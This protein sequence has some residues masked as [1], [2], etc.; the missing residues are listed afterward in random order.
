M[1]AYTDIFRALTAGKQ[2]SAGEASALLAQQ[3][4]EVGDEF[5]N[6]LVQYAREQY[7]QDDRGTHASQRKARLRHGAVTQAAGWLRRVTA[8]GR[9]TTTPTQRR[10]S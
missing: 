5:A 1:S 7:P 8:T 3:R 10:A 9:L 6:A 4:Q 2:L